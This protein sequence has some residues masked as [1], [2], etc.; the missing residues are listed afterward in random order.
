MRLTSRPARRARRSDPRVKMAAA[1]LIAESEADP[2]AAPEPWSPDPGPQTLACQ[3]AADVIGYGGAAGGGK[4]DLILGLAKTQHHKSI[5]FRREYPQLKD[6]IRRA[7]ELTEGERASFNGND[8][9]LTLLGG[10][11]IE[12]GAMRDPDDWEKYKGRPHDLKAYDEVTEFTEDQVRKS[13]GWLRTTREGQRCRVVMTFNPPTSTEGQWVVRFFGP[14]LDRKHP[15]PARPGELRWYATIGGEDVERPDGEPFEFEGETIVPTS[16]T[17]FPARLADNPRLMRTGYGRTLMSLPEPLRSQLLYGDFSAGVGDDPW[18]VIPTAWVEAA[19]ERWEAARHSGRP[20]PPMTVVGVD[21]AHGGKDKTAIARRHDWYFAPLLVYPG[22]E[23]PNGGTAASL[24]VAAQEGD[25]YFN[26]DVIGYG[27]SAYERLAE[28]PPGGH[29][30]QAQPVNFASRS[31]HTDRSGKYGM[32]NL[33]AE[34]YWRLREELDPENGSTVALPP[35]PELKSELCAG[36]FEVTPVGIK[37]EPKAA[38]AER[39]GHSPDRADAVA[40]TTLPNGLAQRGCVGGPL[41]QL[42]PIPGA[43]LPPPPFG[44]PGSLP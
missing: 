28:M 10:Q 17:F 41:P 32:A 8:N 18:Q 37:I 29:G 40:L 35:D 9:L 42:A 24:A 33:R 39:L 15:R 38:I 3:S 4:T 44:I 43:D 2:D 26:V 13:M 16:R 12:F 22:K 6:I 23:T 25:A 19:M 31:E 27:A 36:R 14:W 21:V 1:R 30:K 7:K 11:T 5:I 20:I 34:A